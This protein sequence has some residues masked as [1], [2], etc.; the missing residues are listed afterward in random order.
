MPLSS[1]S[2][3]DTM[4]TVYAEYPSDTPQNTFFLLRK[5]TNLI[6]CLYQKM[7]MMFTKLEL[8]R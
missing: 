8:Q 5:I 6:G 7:F 3:L 1:L 2:S 4:G